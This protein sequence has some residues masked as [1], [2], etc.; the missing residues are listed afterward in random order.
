MTID[1]SPEKIS[2]MF[3][4]IAYSYDKNNN[5]ISLG[6]H[7]IIKK[8]AIKNL[9][10]IDGYKILDICCGTGDV[11]KIFLDTNYK[12]DIT[13]VDFS[14][15]MLSVCKKYFSDRVN[16]LKA[17]ATNLPFSDNTFDII[18]MTFGLRN[19]QDRKKAMQEAYRVLKPNGKL[20][21]L[22]F[23]SKNFPS[24]IF[25]I[26]AVIGIK[27]FYGNQL[28]YEYLIASKK[29]FPEP[30]SLIKEFESVDF[31]FEKRKDFL[32]GIISMQIFN[33]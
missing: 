14:E 13:G 32:F 21:H 1:K 12:L 27:I 2:K 6:T 11:E 9:K 23:G 22:D 19:I 8:I 4:D 29:E 7:N 16:F 20:L 33:K 10:L 28:P 3:D 26:I 31:S 24:K 25:D 18:T 17:D 15:K 5:I 30:N